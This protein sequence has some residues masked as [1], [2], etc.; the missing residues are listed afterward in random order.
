LA[1]DFGKPEGGFWRI[2]W[3]EWSDPPDIRRDLEEFF[4]QIEK[5]NE[6]PRPHRISV[7]RDMYRK[8]LYGDLDVF[9]EAEGQFQLLGKKFGKTTM[10]LE[11]LRYFQNMQGE[12]KPTRIPNFR[13][14]GPKRAR[15]RQIPKSN[16]D[17]V[18]QRTRWKQERKQRR[19]NPGRS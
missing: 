19:R 18:D 6:T 16:R 17:I 13:L 4:K 12:K 9:R 7:S 11:A 15:K 3:D 2:V 1:L 10:T 5:I 8:V 14:D